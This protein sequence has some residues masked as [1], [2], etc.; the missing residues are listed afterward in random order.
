MSMGFEESDIDE[1][2]NL[3]KGLDNDESNALTDYIL[4][5][6]TKNAIEN[7]INNFGS[8]LNNLFNI[9][10]QRFN[11]YSRAI[12]NDYNIKIFDLLE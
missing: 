12:S 2:F 5:H 10:Y 6:T 1:L 9:Y 11:E 4:S 7:E 8:E 3:Y